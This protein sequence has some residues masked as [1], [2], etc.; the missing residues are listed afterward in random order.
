MKKGVESGS[1]SQRYG[2]EIRIRTKMSRNPTMLMRRVV[3]PNPEP[4]G[5]IAAKQRLVCVG[6]GCHGS[7]SS[8][9]V[10]IG[11]ETVI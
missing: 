1:N 9:T 11:G 5:Q 2:S 4:F 3:D 6:V 10:K 7:L 8:L